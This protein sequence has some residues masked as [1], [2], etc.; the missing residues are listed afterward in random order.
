MK[1]GLYSITDLGIWYHGPA[2]T[3]KE[4]ISQARRLGY[5]GVEIDGKRP[6]GNPMDL[7][8]RARAEIRDHLAREGMALA[9]IASN[10]DFSSP[11]PEHRECQMLMV[12][13]QIRLARDLG[14][15]VVRLF[16][17][18]PGV[19]MRGPV[20]TYEVSHPAWQRAF[21]EV[22]AEERWGLV[23]GCLAEVSRIAEDEGIT[24]ALQ[25]HA[26]VIERYQDMLRLI[27]EVDSPALKACL[28][29]P[30]LREQD[31]ESVRR[32]ALETGELQALSHFGGEFERAPDGTA[33]PY[34]YA[35]PEQPDHNYP[36]FVRAMAEIG[37]DGFINYELCHPIRPRGTRQ[38]DLDFVHEQAELAISYMRGVLRQAR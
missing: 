20:A 26:P 30:L 29:L 11:V 27:H 14:A 19:T 35:G 37:Y 18:W 31:D 16:A 32:A 24:L 6:H 3:I 22:S 9:A 33:R 34:K 15:P 21:P 4:F 5:E 2:L 17:A 12:R 23:R 13:E 25:N 28:D 10:N 38:P 7:D 36:A 8:T 1:I